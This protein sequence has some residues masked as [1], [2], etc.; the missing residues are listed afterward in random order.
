MVFSC[1]CSIIAET[2]KFHGFNPSRPEREELKSFPVLLHFLT[3][4]GSRATP[5]ISF[6]TEIKT[7]G[8]VC[9]KKSNNSAYDR[10]CL[11]K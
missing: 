7:D 11:L 9:R 5:F 6:F 3:A 10:P 2:S 4:S 1:H 8:E